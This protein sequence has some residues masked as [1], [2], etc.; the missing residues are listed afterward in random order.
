M[1]LHTKYGLPPV[2]P[3]SLEA[4]TRWFAPVQM[5]T[6]FHY[7]FMSLSVLRHPPLT[8]CLAPP[9]CLAIYHAAAFLNHTPLAKTSFVGKRV[10]AP[11]YNALRNAQR[12]ALIFN[13]AAEV[14]TKYGTE[15]C[16][17]LYCRDMN[18]CS[19]EDQVFS[20]FFSCDF[21]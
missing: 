15:Y 17:V 18:G 5:S 1:K 2:R 13:A 6:D 12:E 3:L 16:I 9:V 21:S 20:Q 19:F 14:S 11:A 4:L 10:M 7:L 8:I